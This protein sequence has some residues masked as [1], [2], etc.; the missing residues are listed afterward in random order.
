M[1]EK[2]INVC[3]DRS[4]HGSKKEETDKMMKGYVDD[5]WLNDG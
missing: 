4:I 5:R 1:G 3:I 2:W